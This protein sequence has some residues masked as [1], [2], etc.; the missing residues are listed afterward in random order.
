VSA[1]KSG[2]LAEFAGQS[3]ELDSGGAEHSRVYNMYIFYRKDIMLYNQLTF[4]FLTF[5]N[6]LN[7][8]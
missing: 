6:G 5:G 8:V 4:S 3:P 1:L 7:I 2:F